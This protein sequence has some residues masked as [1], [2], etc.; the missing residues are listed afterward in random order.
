MF[1]TEPAADAKHAK[2][3]KCSDTGLISRDTPSGHKVASRCDCQSV[4]A[5]LIGLGFGKEWASAT[6]EDYSPAMQQKAREELLTL[7]R[8]MLIT[9]T[10]GVGK[11]HFLAALC[12]EW[13]KAGKGLRFYLA[14]ALF[15]RIW[16][17]HRDEAV[18][19]TG[20][21]INDLCNVQILAID[22]IGNAD[23]SEAERRVLHEILS[24]RN[25]EELITVVT[26]NLP[27]RSEKA[28]NDIERMYGP[29]IASRMS[30]WLLVP[31]VGKDR[32]Q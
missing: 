19:S 22:D 32:R 17:T 16:A 9:G 29:P 31:M 23:A 10:T 20:Q 14:A 2:C 27:L 26:T 3:G 30:G 25:G 24:Q 8:G 4:R 5:R 12:G 7:Q 11:T 1:P 15:R 28:T 6:L 21:V 13:L 18:E